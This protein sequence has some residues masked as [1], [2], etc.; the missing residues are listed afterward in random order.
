[1][2]EDTLERRFGVLGAVAILGGAL[3]VAGSAPAGEGPQAGPA[4]G[5]G[6][7]KLLAGFEPEQM[8]AWGLNKPGKDPNGHFWGLQDDGSY[9]WSTMGGARGRVVKG[10]A[11]QGEWALAHAIANNNQLGWVNAGDRNEW[12]RHTHGSLA[13]WAG[14]FQKWFPTDWS[15]YGRLRMDFKSAKAAVRVRVILYD[16][17]ALPPA[18]RVFPV[19]PGDWVT[20]DFDLAGASKL[21]E[22]N[23]SEE[24]ARLYGAK[25]AKLRTFNP[26]RMADMIVM[27][28]QADGLTDLFLDNVRLVADEGAEK[29][30]R[31]LISDPRPFPEPRELSPGEPK[32]RD[33]SFLKANA[34]PPGKQEPA[35]IT[36]K[37]GTDYDRLAFGAVAAAGMD[38][39]ILC[40][41]GQMLNTTATLDGGKTWKDLEKLRHTKNAPGVGVAAAGPDLLAAYVA[42]CAGGGAPTD[43]FFRQA[44]FDG[45][46]WAFSPPA[47]MDVDSWHCPE[48]K[49]RVLRLA[50]GRIWTAW[51]QDGRTRRIHVKAR[52][53]D[54]GGVTWRDPDS[55][56]LAEF[57]NRQDTKGP[58]P[59][60]V[61]WWWEEPAI[62]PPLE[63]AN[64]RIGACDPHGNLALTPYG[65]HVA[66]LWGL[67][68]ALVWSQFDGKGWSEPKTAVRG[69]GAPGSATTLDGKGIHVIF[70]GKVY[71]LDGENWV[72]DSP[73]EQGPA[74][75]AVSGNV[76]LC[77]GKKAA[78]AEGKPIAE[79][80]VSRKISGGTWSKP[81]VI[82]REETKGISLTAPQYAPENV[83]PVAW[84]PPREWIKVLR[85]PVEQPGK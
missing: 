59:L 25:V 70:A 52:Y 20:L 40:H 50:S 79:L 78:E 10:E 69:N 64:G 28:E 32:P 36:F 5:G 63:K 8:N 27:V 15:G 29:P 22:M 46:G 68:N 81:D 67:N 30:A 7:V 61:T 82:A 19:P 6:K 35:S 31:K 12:L 54:D 74:R 34:A 11:T 24:A 43:A 3:A 21:H 39:T 44:T 45:N 48:W 65:D 57:E 55:N 49:M 77:I 23:L 47:L 66:C 18:V 26:A 16:E 51:F 73:A 53:S 72:E 56:G 13:K 58:M 76:L 84:G 2:R 71:R 1:M 9:R 38:R 33:L 37:E 41:G 75:L 83:V 80:W 4:A 62:T 42:R 17:I 85:I 14:H 60:G